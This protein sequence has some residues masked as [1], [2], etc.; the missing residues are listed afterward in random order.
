MRTSK[1]REI[2]VLESMVEGKIDYNKMGVEQVITVTDPVDGD[3]ASF[4]VFIEE[5]KSE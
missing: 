2:P 3:S 4:T 1:G 5:M